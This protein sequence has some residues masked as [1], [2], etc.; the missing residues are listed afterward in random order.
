MDPL[1]YSITG[2]CAGQYRAPLA[3]ISIYVVA[4][5]SKAKGHETR[6]GP[7]KSELHP[8]NVALMTN[9]DATAL[10]ASIYLG[11]CCIIVLDVPGIKV[12]EE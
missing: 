12:R 9:V 8:I 7:R 11:T 5:L 3:H 10:R 4:K 6:I 1:R 2:A